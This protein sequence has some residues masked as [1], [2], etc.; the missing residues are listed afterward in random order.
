MK[1]LDRTLVAITVIAGIWIVLSWFNVIA[2]NTQ[3]E[4]VYAAWNLFTLMLP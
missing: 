3:P 1:A 2:H 4:P